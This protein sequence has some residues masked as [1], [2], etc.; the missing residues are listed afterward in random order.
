[1]AFMIVSNEDVRAAQTITGATFTAFILVGFVPGLR[2]YAPRIRIG[3][4]VAYLL[5]AAGFMI[6]LTV[7]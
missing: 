6:Y 1:M 5:I 3:I 2:P 7:R 4:T